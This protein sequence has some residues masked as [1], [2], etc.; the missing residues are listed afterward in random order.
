MI[1]VDWSI[2]P[3]IL[4]FLLT[5]VALNSLLFRP[6]TRVQAEREKKTTGLMSQTRQDLAHHLQLFDQY[7]A[8]LKN[9]RLEGYR[10]IEKVRSGALLRRGEALDEARKSAQGLML[11]ARGSIQTQVMEAKAHLEREAR[12]MAGSIASAILKRSA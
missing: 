8:T 7:Q 12:E 10:L 3:A 1:S 2:I 9:G 6:V 11:E 5:I 4:I